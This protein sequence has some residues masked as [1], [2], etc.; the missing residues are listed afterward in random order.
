MSESPRA[1]GSRSEPPPP[2]DPLVDT[3]AHLDDPRLRPHLGEIL[4]RARRAGVVQVVA[5]ATT[6][7]DSADVVAIAAEQPGVFAAVGFQ[8]NNVVDAVEGDWERIVELASAPRVVALGETGLDRHWD[9]APFDLQQAWFQRHL[10][11]ARERD[12]PV[13]IHCRECEA[14]VAAQLAAMGSPVRGVLH[15]FTGD[16]KQA[17]AFLDLGLHISFAGMLTFANKKLDALREAA[18]A[19]PLDRLLV[20]TDSPYLAPHP[21]RGLGN[22]PAHVVW[23]ARKLAELR[24][25]DESELACAVTANARALFRLPEAD[26]IS[27][28]PCDRS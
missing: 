15:S 8:P 7:A 22:E 4:G 13:V 5:I 18:A 20:E 21:L 14:D 1:S 19:V 26:L 28:S 16:R 9:R 3:H 25:M 6:A 27:P 17:E 24:G 12:L 23:T 11:L 10:D 2:L